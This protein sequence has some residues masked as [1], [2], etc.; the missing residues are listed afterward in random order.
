VGSETID[1]TEAKITI[2]AGSLVTKGR[3]VDT[4]TCGANQRGVPLASSSSKS[5]ENEVIESDSTIAPS[6]DPEKPVKTLLD[7]EGKD[8]IKT[9]SRYG[10]QGNG[11]S[12]SAVSVKTLMESEDIDKKEAMIAPM[13]ESLTKDSLV[14][15]A[16]CG[17]QANE[18]SVPELPAAVVENECVALTRPIFDL[19]EGLASSDDVVDEEPSLSTITVVVPAPISV[20]SDEVGFVP[21]SDLVRSAEILGQKAKNAFMQGE[22]HRARESPP[23][24]MTEESCKPPL[25]TIEKSEY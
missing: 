5:L 10:C 4:S 12:V 22:P 8:C 11:E 20:I 21:P 14:V 9:A 3:L 13:V 17:G 23:I 1:K 15:S 6:F 19:N 7:S 24:G 18:L 2:M 16:E 25:T